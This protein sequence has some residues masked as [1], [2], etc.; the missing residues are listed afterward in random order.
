MKYLIYISVLIVSFSSSAQQDS[1]FDRS[2]LLLQKEKYRE[3]NKQLEQNLSK[4]SNNLAAYFNLGLSFFELKEYGNA[5][6]AFEK[7]LR[8]D[9]SNV[10]VENALTLTYLKVDPDGALKL[11][12][13]SV[14]VLAKIRPFIWGLFGI[15]SSLLISFI[16]YVLAKGNQKAMR[17]FFS[18]SAIILCAGL[19]FSIY[20]GFVSSDFREQSKKGVIIEEALIYLKDFTPSSNSLPL[21]S[22]VTFQDSLDNN[23]VSV[24]TSKNEEVIIELPT[25]RPL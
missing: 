16:L 8:M 1:L 24:R 17:G 6:W 11:E 7:C 15:I 2:V 25:L 14:P 23:F 13:T 20:G 21:G 3:A 19:A 10:D 12:Q 5:I 9:P 4:D 22:V 18:F